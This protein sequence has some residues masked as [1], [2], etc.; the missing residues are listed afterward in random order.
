MHIFS[1]RTHYTWIPGEELSESIQPIK[2]LS[3]RK[4][5]NQLHWMKG[6]ELGIL[7]GC[8]FVWGWRSRCTPDK[9][10]LRQFVG[11]NCVGAVGC[12]KVK[13]GLSLSCIHGCSK[14]KIAF[15]CAC[16]LSD[17]LRSSRW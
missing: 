4:Y 5:L 6:Q 8:L 12:R 1:S 16:R 11:E 7:L 3:R 14:L 10:I 17:S 13:L 2:V 15:C 9:W